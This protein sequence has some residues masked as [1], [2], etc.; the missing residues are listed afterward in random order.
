[1]TSFDVLYHR[2]VEDDRAAVREIVRVMKP[3]GSSSCACPP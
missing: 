1:V 3:G 2:W